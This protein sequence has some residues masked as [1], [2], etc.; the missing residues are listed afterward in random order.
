MSNLPKRVQLN[1]TASVVTPLERHVR[2]TR[3]DDDERRRANVSSMRE[4]L[5]R[6]DADTRDA[7]RAVTK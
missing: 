7:K 1:S 2:E 6:A 4:C 5:A 3:D